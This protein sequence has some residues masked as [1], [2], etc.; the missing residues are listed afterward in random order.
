MARRVQVQSSWLRLGLL[1]LWWPG[2][3]AALLLCHPKAF[4]RLGSAWV[5][6]L[7]M[8][9]MAVVTL[10][11]A[12]RISIT[13]GIVAISYPF[14]LPR[15][16]YLLLAAEVQ[17]VEVHRGTPHALLFHMAAHL[18]VRLPF[19]GLGPAAIR[20]LKKELAWAGISG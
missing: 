18:R 17:A 6:W 12:I 1:N 15:R 16:T 9:P 2:L 10:H 3:Q 19:C 11:F 8:V 7:P 13:D 5:L 14:R 4:D 20:G